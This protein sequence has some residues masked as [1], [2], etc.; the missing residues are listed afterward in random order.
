MTIRKTS[1]Y[2]KRDCEQMSLCVDNI[3]LDIS[4][5]RKSL[6]S[7]ER[8]SKT[9]LKILATRLKTTRKLLDNVYS[10]IESGDIVSDIGQIL[11]II[12]PGVDHWFVIGH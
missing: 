11:N 8:C 2:L 5:I 7:N 12:E 4:L 1:G 10:D 3:L 9:D 6:D